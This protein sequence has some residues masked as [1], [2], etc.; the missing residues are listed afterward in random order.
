MIALGSA[1]GWVLG[2][3]MGFI[4]S[5]ALTARTAVLFPITF[6]GR[7]AMMAAALIVIGMILAV[8]P[9]LRAYAHPVSRDLRS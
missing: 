4:I 9:A 5:T 8:I 6:S 2:Y 3:V 1:A 7:E